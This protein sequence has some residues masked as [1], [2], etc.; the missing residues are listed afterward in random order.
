MRIETERDD[1][2]DAILPDGEGESAFDA[3]TLEELGDE[4]GALGSAVAA[5]DATGA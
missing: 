5:S 3:W 2:P 1:A 4:L